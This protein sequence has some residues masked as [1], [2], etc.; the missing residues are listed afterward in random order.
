MNTIK[1]IRF[2]GLVAA[3]LFFAQ[4]NKLEEKVYSSNTEDNFFQS[5]SDVNA[6]ITGMYRPMQACCGGYGQSGHFILNGTSDE[7]TGADFWGTYDRLDYTGSSTGEIPDWWN[8]SYRAIAGANLITDNQVKIEAVDKTSDKSI[9]KAAIGEAKFWRAVN[10]FQLVQMFGGVPVRITQAKRA[11]ETNKPRNSVEEVYAQIILDFKDAEQGLMVSPGPGK[12][13]KW[14]ATAYLAKVYLTQKD[15]PNALAKANEAISS[16]AYALAPKFADVFDI[17]KENGKEDIFAI[18][19]V[20]VD[21]QG[22][23]LQELTGA[24]GISGIEPNL[25]PKYASQDDRKNTTFAQPMSPTSNQ[26]K[27]LDPLKVSADGSANNFIVYRYADLILVKAE[28]ENEVNGASTAAY[29][30]IN[31]IRTRANLPNLTAGLTKDQF[32]DS[33]LKERNLEL[34][35]EEIRWFD[36]KRTER[37]K[38]TLIATGRTW[39]DKYYLFPIPQSEVDASN[40]LIKQNDGY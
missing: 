7:G 28:A 39:N 16:G 37:L 34:A 6:A 32:R 12:V 20:R 18:Q 15:Y 21:P 8:S 9:S 5:Q 24:W 1:L 23:R 31:K 33:V 26:G 38:S 17:T 22:M 36:L 11:D 40:G 13:S 30:E 29:T 14:A 25:Y 27:W 19:F 35:M 4:C 10:Y 3:T 2:S